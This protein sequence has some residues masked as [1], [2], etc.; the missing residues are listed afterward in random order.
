MCT[1]DSRVKLICKFKFGDSNEK[2]KIQ[3]GVKRKEEIKEKEK[4]LALGRRTNF[5]PT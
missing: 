2:G 3:I 1:F 5:W 4:K